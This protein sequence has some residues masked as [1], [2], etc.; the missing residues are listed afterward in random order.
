MVEN[1]MNRRSNPTDIHV[2]ERI[3]MRRLML[4]MSQSDLGDP[5]GISSQQIQ[6]YENGVNR[7]SASRLQQFAKLLE[8]P[9]SFFFDGLAPS[10]SMQHSQ[11]EDLAPQLVSTRLGLKLVKAFNAIEDSSI[12]RAI[13]RLVEDIARTSIRAR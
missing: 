5:C 11:P 2:G 10:D 12:R 1:Q 9:V 6:K 13:V 7:V 3:K 8:V 4:N